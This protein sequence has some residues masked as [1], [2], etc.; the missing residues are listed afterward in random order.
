MSD[1]NVCLFVS[2]KKQKTCNNNAT[3][4]KKSVAKIH[5]NSIEYLK[6]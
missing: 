1:V 4:V 2:G 6:N 3:N 5:R